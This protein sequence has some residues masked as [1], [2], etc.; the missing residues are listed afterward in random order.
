MEWLLHEHFALTTDDATGLCSRLMRMGYF[1]GVDSS[2]RAFASD[3]TLFH[4]N[5]DLLDD[6]SSEEE[7]ESDIDSIHGLRG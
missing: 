2:T 3:D 6:S 4:W 5:P 1:F 7:D